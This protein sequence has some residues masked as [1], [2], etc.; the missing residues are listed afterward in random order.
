MSIPPPPAVRVPAPPTATVPTAK[1]PAPPTATVPTATVPAPPTAAVP[2]AT[3]P[4]PPTAAPPTATVPTAKV[5][6]PPTATVPAPPAATALSASSVPPVVSVPS[7]A[8]PQLSVT[9]PFTGASIPSSLP[10]GIGVSPQQAINDE[11][12]RSLEKAAIQQFTSAAGDH[13][14]DLDD[15]VR[16]TI[17]KLFF[18]SNYDVGTMMTSIAK[19]L[20]CLGR[21]D[22]GLLRNDDSTAFTLIQSP[23]F[24][25]SVVTDETQNFEKCRRAIQE[26]K[27]RIERADT[28]SKARFFDVAR[29]ETKPN[30]K[31]LREP[32]PCVR[33]EAKAKPATFRKTS[34]EQIQEFLRA[35]RASGVGRGRGASAGSRVPQNASPE[36]DGYLLWRYGGKYPKENY[37]THYRLH[38]LKK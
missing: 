1:V 19:S 12:R 25:E 21:Y 4:T 34:Y 29:A 15:V 36:R 27:S 14:L 38:G 31:P 7:G 28:R 8:V 32:S 37:Y 2:T 11:A 6:A 26:A 24:N 30:E 16:D 10:A 20:H 17:C 33:R 13:Y 3:V 23:P 35:Y 22:V 9:A 18:L 5:P